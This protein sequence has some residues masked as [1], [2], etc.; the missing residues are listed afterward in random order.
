V[1]FLIISAFCL[2]ALPAFYT[3]AY[4]ETLPGAGILPVAHVTPTAAQPLQY[5]M[6]KPRPSDDCNAT[7]AHYPPTYSSFASTETEAYLWFYVTGLNA[8]D[9]F[10]TEYYMPDGQFYTAPSDD[11]DP[12]SEGGNWCFTDVAFKIAGYPPASAPGTWTVKVKYNRVQLFQLTFKITP[13]GTGGSVTGYSVN[14]LENPNAEASAATSDCSP[15]SSVPGWT[16]TG[17][18]TVCSYGQ[19]GYPNAD[20]PG[21]PSRGNNF[22][23][24]GFEA[25]STATQSLDVSWAAADIDRGAV[26]YALSGY[27]GG[28]DTQDDNAT[29]KALFRASP[30]GTATQAMIGPVYASDRSGV[31]GLLLRSATGTVPAGT[32]QIDIVQGMTRVSG[33]ANDGYTDSLAFTLTL[34]ASACSYFLEPLS[35]TIPAA[36]G[37]ATLRVAAGAGCA[38]TAVSNVSWISIQAGTFGEDCL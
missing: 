13:G 2:L 7:S 37:T 21:P 35:A 6:T 8:G 29:V 34:G 25:E 1:R 15:G 28:F 26:S 14:L 23:F 9:V 4:G 17:Q 30:F 32:R 33:S 22:F 31:T 27:V 16:A 5:M 18:F 3:P 19:P 36:G 12:V 10:S 20:S 38:W 11:F 24:G